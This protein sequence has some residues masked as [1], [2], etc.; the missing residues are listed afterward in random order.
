[1]FKFQGDTVARIR[2]LVLVVVIS[3]AAGG[4]AGVCS[5]D[6]R[7][8]GAVPSTLESTETKADKDKKPPKVLLEWTIGKK[9]EDKKNDDG[10][11]GK[12]DTNQGD[13]NDNGQ[14]G[15]NSNP[16][17]NAENEQPK[18]VEPDRPHLAEASTT[19]GEGRVVLEAGYTFSEG[20]GGAQLHT[21]PEGLLRIGMFADWFEFRI[22]QDFAS[23]RVTTLGPVAGQGS[24]AGLFQAG[25]I[26]SHT[27]E[28]GP[29]IAVSET[30]AQDL[31]LG[32]KLGLTEQKKWLPESALVL[33]MTV[34]T[35]SRAFTAGQVL[36][37]VNYDVTWEIV[38]NFFALEGIISANRVRDDT[39]HFYIIIA[40]GLTPTV[41]LTRQLEAFVDLFGFF[42]EG[43]VSRTVGPQ[44][45]AV[46]GLQYYV[47]L[48]LALDVRAGLGLTKHS[49]DYLVGTGF[50]ARY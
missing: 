46:A 11:K 6:C 22:G 14:S 19:V 7:W 45:Y 38:K 49:S 41:N 5:V 27:G 31:Y 32:V 12:K 23:H 39:G 21:Y 28:T 8:P 1:L 4:C 16:E 9:E 47:T 44:Y 50:T 35:G 33:Q 15:K 3:F 20:P 40:E 29:G 17:N 25:R 26:L 36:P 24:T 43:A 18:K 34:P 2:R 48:N 13:Q 30:G 42:A 37:G 10:K